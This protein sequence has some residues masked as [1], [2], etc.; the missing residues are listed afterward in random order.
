MMKEPQQFITGLAF[1]VILGVVGYWSIL[2][3]AQ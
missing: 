1:G 2:A 3:M